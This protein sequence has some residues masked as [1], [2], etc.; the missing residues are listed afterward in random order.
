MNLG[1]VWIS[2]EMKGLN[3]DCEH[4]KSFPPGHL[5]SS[6][7]GIIGFVSNRPFELSLFMKES[8]CCSRIELLRGPDLSLYE[9]QPLHQKSIQEVL[10]IERPS[11]CWLK[12][13]ILFQPSLLFFKIT[14]RI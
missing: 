8:Y 6:K 14:V 3:D 5:Y 11:K 1:S 2:S 10:P 13:L 4:F 9:I 12:M 7:E